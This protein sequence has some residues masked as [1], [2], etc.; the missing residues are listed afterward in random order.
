MFQPGCFGSTMQVHM[1]LVA[2]INQANFGAAGK[3]IRENIW[4]KP[5]SQWKSEKWKPS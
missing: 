2:E 1:Q 5:P 3:L 4:W